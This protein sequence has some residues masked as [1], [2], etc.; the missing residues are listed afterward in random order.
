MLHRD[1]EFTNNSFLDTHP[2][3]KQLKAHGTTFTVDTTNAC[4][5]ESIGSTVK[6]YYGAVWIGEEEHQTS[7]VREDSTFGNAASEVRQDLTRDMDE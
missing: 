6:N 5:N 2:N 4:I 3:F 7:R 1:G